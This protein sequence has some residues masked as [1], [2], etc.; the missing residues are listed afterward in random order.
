MMAIRSIAASQ[1]ENAV[2]QAAL[3]ANTRLPADIMHALEQ[4]ETAESS[5]NGRKV[6]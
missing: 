1:I 4:A 5:E 3:E 6:L 2:Y